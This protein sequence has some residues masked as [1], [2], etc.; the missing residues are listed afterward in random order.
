LQCIKKGDALMGLELIIG[1]T[2]ISV[3]ALTLADD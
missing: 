2:L 3:L 1:G